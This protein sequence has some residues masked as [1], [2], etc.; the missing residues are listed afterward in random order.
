M[1]VISMKEFLKARGEAPRRRNG[2][3]SA[4][5]AEVK[6]LSKMP[7]GGAWYHEA[8]IVEAGTDKPTPLPH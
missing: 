5:A 2:M 6:T 4:S 8:A 3:A 7:S 1:T